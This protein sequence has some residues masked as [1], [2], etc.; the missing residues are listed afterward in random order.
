MTRLEFE[1]V[2]RAAGAIYQS[3][4][5]ANDASVRSAVRAFWGPTLTAVDARTNLIEAD[6]W[7]DFL[8]G[9]YNELVRIVD[10]LEDSRCDA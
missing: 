10:P 1:S 3:V 9:R 5:R 6:S 2:F 8:P 4:R 7:I